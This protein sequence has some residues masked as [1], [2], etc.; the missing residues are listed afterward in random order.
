MVRNKKNSRL[1]PKKMTKDD[2][3]SKN[4]NRVG[5]KLS[6]NDLI[7]V[8]NIGKKEMERKSE[9]QSKELLIN[10]NI[11]IKRMNNPAFFIRC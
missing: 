8:K 7:Q 3:M 1:N 2:K 5:S 9:S 4:T 11:A 6:R 10:D